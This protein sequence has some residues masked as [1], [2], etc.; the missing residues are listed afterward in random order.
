MGLV[1]PVVMHTFNP[2]TWEA[3]ADR[4][5]SLGTA[6]STEFQYSQ[7]YIKKYY[8]GK[9]KERDKGWGKRLTKS[10]RPA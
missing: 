7:G 1:E 9:K 2:S 8:L 4:T 3:K 5:L 10:S 6:W